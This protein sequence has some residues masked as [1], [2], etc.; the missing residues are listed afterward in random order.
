MISNS[1][2]SLIEE[3]AAS[4]GV[5][6][7]AVISGPHRSVQTFWTPDTIP[8]EPAFLAYSIT[9]SF[10]AVALLLLQEQGLL[11]LDAPLADWFPDVPGAGEM[12]LRQVL[13][14]TAGL[15]D[16]G[17]LAAYHAAV[18]N[19]PSHPW[20]F[21]EFMERTLAEG[22]DFES[23]EDW[24]Y[25]NLGYMFLKRILEQRTGESFS[26]LLTR[27]IIRPLSLQRTVVPEQVADLSS[28]A[29]APSTLLHPEGKRLDTRDHYHPG[30]VSHGVLASTA[31]EIA[32]FYDSVFRGQL[33]SGES[34]GQMTSL[35]PVPIYDSDSPWSK[36][37]YGLGLMAD[38]EFVC[39]P[40]F[41]HNGD[42]PG[43]V[44]SAYYAPDLGKEGMTVCVMSGIEEGFDAEQVVV[45][46]MDM[47]GS[48]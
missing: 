15:P 4:R 29:P 7:L 1:L 41:G 21:E 22:L 6:A 34:L 3:H 12:S 43:Y 31:S 11:N 46:V 8:T 39:G 38:P 28:L 33:I 47:V 23:G 16:Y 25:S 27:L 48:R 40:V 45:E 13:H 30:W 24:G 5:A 9:K 44:S 37:S 19:S 2:R 35:V 14:H 36:P 32:L 26:V 42:G 17:P 20:T 10:T 18:R